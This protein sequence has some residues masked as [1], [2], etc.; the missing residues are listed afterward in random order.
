MHGHRT[1]KHNATVA[2][3]CGIV[4]LHGGEVHGDFTNYYG[5][6]VDVEFPTV[7]R[8]VMF[9]TAFPDW[10]INFRDLVNNIHGSCVLVIKAT[11]K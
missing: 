8:A 1:I 9:A 7:L 11:G 6:F 4:K 3:I 2:N 5:T 10:T